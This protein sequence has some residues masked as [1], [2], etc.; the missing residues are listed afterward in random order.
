MRQDEPDDPRRRTLI[1]ALAA[2]LLSYGAVGERAVAQ[3][4]FGGRPGKLPEGRSIYRLSGKVMVNDAVATQAT[5]IRA[6]DT[7]KTGA[8][9]EI[10][11]VVGGNSMIVRRNSTV[12]LGSPPKAK[13]SSFFL[14]ALR[15]VT[16]A[17]LSVSRNR[18]MRISTTTATIGIRGTGFYMEAEPDRTYFCTCYG[19]TDIGA[20]ADPESKTRVVAT[21]HDRP[22]Y[23]VTDGGTGKNIRTAPFVNHTDQELALI[24]ALVGREP[25]FVFPKSN[26][27]GPRRRY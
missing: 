26:Y 6:G 22:V 3:G 8:D 16:G 7:V 23:I 20:V 4:L 13:S 24:E 2:G 14:S 12:S 27:S 25:P 9:G 21:H 17:I 11:F 5:P 1:R 18:P 10:I 15:L 19:L